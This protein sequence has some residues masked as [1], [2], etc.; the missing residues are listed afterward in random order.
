MRFSR[1]GYWSG[2]PFPSPGDLPNPGIE[3]WP[4]ALRADSLPTE[5]QGKPLF[6]YKIKF[7]L[8]WTPTTWK[9][10]LLKS[11]FPRNCPVGFSSIQ[12]LSN[13]LASL[14]LFLSPRCYLLSIL[15]F[16]DCS[17]QCKFFI[18]YAEHTLLAG[19]Y[20]QA[21]VRTH[22]CISKRTE[23]FNKWKGSCLPCSIL[24]LGL[25]QCLRI[26]LPMLEMW[27]RSLGCEDPLEKDMV[28]PLQ[29]SCLEN[30]M[31]RGAW[32]AAVHGVAKDSDT[33]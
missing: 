1:Q 25:P 6:Q 27:V 13:T 2:L 17:L 28:S 16:L 19:V 31:D 10:I 24:L 18:L 22:F 29:Y 5:L 33:T 9:L 3:P 21:K 7:I 20:F 26:H 4:P 11:S 14:F 32:Q 23:I 8:K 30:P 12:G 15:S